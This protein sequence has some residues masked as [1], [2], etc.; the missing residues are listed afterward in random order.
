MHVHPTQQQIE[1]I[2]ALDQDQP[3]TMLNLLR[4]NEHAKTGL[5]CDGMTGREAYEE[6]GRRVAALDPPFKGTP[7]WLGDGVATVIGPEDE[8]WD[9]I[10]LV[11]YD[12]ASEFLSAVSRADYLEA[13][14]ARD[15]A[16][17]DSRLVMMHELHSAI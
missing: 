7:I 2:M 14:P 17:A 5:G 3:V 15:A 4:F 13:A 16:I 6:Y 12:T 10:L 9:Q 11:K 1:A 8:Q